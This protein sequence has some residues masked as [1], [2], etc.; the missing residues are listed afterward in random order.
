MH[1]E[2]REQKTE[3]HPA[4]TIYRLSRTEIE[5]AVLEWIRAKESLSL[6]GVAINVYCPDDFPCG[7]S[8]QQHRA[9]VTHPVTFKPNTEGE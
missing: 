1:K 5:A 6:E 8:C 9:V 4:S 7:E 2:Y 3:I